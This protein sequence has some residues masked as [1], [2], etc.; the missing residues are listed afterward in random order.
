MD[1]I[2]PLLRGYS[3][4]LRFFYRMVKQIHFCIKMTNSCVCAIVTNFLSHTNLDIPGVT[5][6]KI[7]TVKNLLQNRRGNPR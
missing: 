6:L 5:S 3:L 7:E 4:I 2:W 1:L